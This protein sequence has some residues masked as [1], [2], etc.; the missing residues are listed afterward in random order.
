VTISH[1]DH[2]H[3]G[4]AAGCAGHGDRC[5]VRERLCHRGDHP[6]AIGWAGQLRSNRGVVDIALYAAGRT[7][8]LALFALGA[9]YK[10]A[11]STLLILGALAG[12]V[13]LLDAGIGLFEH[14][15]GIA[16]GRSLLPSSNS[17]RCICFTDPCGSRH[18][19]SA[20]K[21]ALWPGTSKDFPITRVAC[22]SGPLA[23]LTEGKSPCPA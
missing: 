15:L 19:S 14:D 12:A 8:P 5:P 17:S 22:H 13:Q 1:Q 10:R 23:R 18:K 7:I 6:P 9:I 21:R 2:N 3:K 20:D 4:D 16:A 11:T